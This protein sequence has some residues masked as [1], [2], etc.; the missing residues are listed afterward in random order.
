MSSS[1]K[2]RQ[3]MAKMTRERE[4]R[5]KRVRKQE[6]KDEKKQAAAAAQIAA[7]AGIPLEGAEGEDDAEEVG[8]TLQASVAGDETASG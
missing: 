5:E 6:K 7:E 8:S 1:T 2:K 4:L 3:T